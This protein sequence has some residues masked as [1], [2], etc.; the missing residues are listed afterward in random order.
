M[1]FKFIALVI[2]LSTLVM[3][4]TMYFFYPYDPYNPPVANDTG[5]TQDGLASV[6]D[7]N[8]Q[9]AFTIYNEFAQ[10]QSE[11]IFF[12][13]YS[14]FSALAMTYEGAKEQTASQ[15]QQVFSFPE[16]DVLQPNFAALYNSINKANAPYT[17]RV[18]NA[19]WVEES[20][21]L[22]DSYKDTVENYYGGK[23]VN[24]DLINQAQE[25]SQIINSF[26]AEQT[27]NRIQDIIPPGFIHRD[28]RL[29]LSNAIYFLGD[30]K[31][32]FNRRDTQ[33]R[34]FYITPDNVIQTDMMYLDPDERLYYGEFDTVEI[35]ELPYKGD[36]VV[37]KIILPK[38]GQYLDMQ[39][40]SVREYNYTLETINMTYQM[41]RNYSNQMREVS[42][43]A[44]YLPKFEFEA[45]YDLKQT[46]S[47][48]G[49]PIA[50]SEQADFS[51]MTGR[52]NLFIDE[53]LHK[54]FIKVDE[55]GTEAA[56]A[57]VVGMTITS[58]PMRELIFNANRPFLFV[59]EQKETDAILF[60]GVVNDPREE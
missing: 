44:I 28:T 29:I 53:V 24:L 51:G 58:A 45:S 5:W 8:N 25:S 30:W 31:Y 6:V 48:L 46:L 55:K 9:F 56:A 39:T 16:S 38:Y 33:S 15:M 27:N 3:A 32:E 47:D 14:I 10:Q 22:L 57:T 40:R 12:S 11:N 18:G 50:F 59:I 7:A 52:P 19:L 23:S 17:L 1:K 36:E 26:I 37:M 20:F 42:M 13:P 4:T 49:M 54:A 43:D 60:M 41:Y 35:L 21:S 34:D 2:V